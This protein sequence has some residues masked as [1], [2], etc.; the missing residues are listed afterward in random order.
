ME[1]V[2]YEQKTKL[3]RY[4]NQSTLI[5]SEYTVFVI[6]SLKEFIYFDVSNINKTLIRRTS[7]LAEI[8]NQWMVV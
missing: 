6:M 5:R 8:C 1:T 4:I 7:Q 2:S 3:R